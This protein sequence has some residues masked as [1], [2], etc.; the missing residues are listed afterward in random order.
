MKLTKLDK[1]KARPMI[2]DSQEVG[3]RSLV[4]KMIVKV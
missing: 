3:P 4:K 1:G 2:D